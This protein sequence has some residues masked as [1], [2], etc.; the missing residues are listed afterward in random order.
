[1]WRDGCAKENK[2]LQHDMLAN[3]IKPAANASGLK[4]LFLRPWCKCLVEKK[5][6]ILFPIPFYLPFGGKHIHILGST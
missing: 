2:A 1:M 4:M 5:Q 6:G 3:Q